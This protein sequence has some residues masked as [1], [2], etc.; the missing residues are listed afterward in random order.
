MIPSDGYS[1]AVLKWE[2]D[3]SDLDIY[4]IPLGVKAPAPTST[5]VHWIAA[6]PSGNTYDPPPTF[7]EAEPPY[8]WWGLAEAGKIIKRCRALVW[9]AGFRVSGMRDR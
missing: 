9:G 5:A 3:P 2:N 6:S 4:V 7:R 1:R 8:L